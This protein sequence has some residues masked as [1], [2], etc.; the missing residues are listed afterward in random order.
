[1]HIPYVFFFKALSPTSA[2]WQVALAMLS[3]EM[4]CHSPYRIFSVPMFIPTIILI[5]V[6]QGFY[7]I[8]PL[9][10]FLNNYT[11]FL[12]QFGDNK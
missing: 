5:L 11:I 3:A 2:I 8:T 4:K 9:I 12:L 7:L 1:V 10:L 6:L